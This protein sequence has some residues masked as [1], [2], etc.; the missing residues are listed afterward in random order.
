MSCMR[1]M[2]IQMVIAIIR[3]ISTTEIWSLKTWQFLTQ[4][5]YCNQARCRL[6]VEYNQLRLIIISSNNTE[7]MIWCSNNNK[8]IILL[9]LL[10]IDRM[11]SQTKSLKL[12]MM[13]KHHARSLNQTFR[14]ACPVTCQVLQTLFLQ[15]WS[16]L[17]SL[18]HWS[19]KIFN[20]ICMKR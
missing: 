13:T 19:K 6:R 7:Q 9:Q 18:T 8:L 15:R 20:Q 1:S 14:W 12:T 2:S 16:L 3:S 5:T 11:V 17:A 10:P 4:I